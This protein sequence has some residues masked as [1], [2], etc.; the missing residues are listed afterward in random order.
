MRTIHHY[1]DLPP[2]AVGGVYAIGKFD[3]LHIGH[4]MLLRNVAR[5][6]R[7]SGEIP[8]VF[9]FEPHPKA[10]LV[11]KGE[12]LRIMSRSQKKE[13]LKYSGVQLYLEQKFDMEFAKLSA[14]QFVADVLRDALRASHV[15]IGHNFRFGRK[16]Q[17]DANQLK[18]LCFASEIGATIVSP[19]EV[20]GHEISSTRV[21]MLIFQGRMDDVAAVLGKPW[22]VEAVPVRVEGLVEFDLSSYTILHGGQYVIRLNGVAFGATVVHKP[23]GQWLCIDAGSIEISNRPCQIEILRLSDIR[24]PKRKFYGGGH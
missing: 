2:D 5:I 24:K 15:V 1:N 11:P 9:S 18:R 19:V 10:I 13:A 4:Q 8:S 20:Q 21:R 23:K 22:R 3:G 14:E 17:G 7:Q 12:V 6:S 16:A